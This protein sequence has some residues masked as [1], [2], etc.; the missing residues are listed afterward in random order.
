MPNKFIV[1]TGNTRDQLLDILDKL[2]SGDMVIF[3]KGVHNIPD[4][5]EL[6][7]SVSTVFIGISENPQDTILNAKIT[8]L[9]NDMFIMKNMTLSSPTSDA[10][11]TVKESS[12]AGC[13]NCIFEGRAE[14]EYPNIYIDNSMLTLA[15]CTVRN[16]DTLQGSIFLFNKA[17]VAVERT[18]I[19]M[20]TMSDNSLLN[21]KM[22]MITTSLAVKNSI[23]YGDEP[24]ELLGMNPNMNALTI[25]D[26]SIAN[27][28]KIVSP[29]GKIS[30]KITDSAL[31]IEELEFP[32]T[33]QNNVSIDA[34]SFS[35]ID[36][37]GK[38]STA[39]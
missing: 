6:G 4:D 10:G 24:V 2:K 23:V 33:K 13:N 7:L 8:I 30:A 32:N 36:I 5:L 26:R 35:I 14:N 17:H 15:E 38:D 11:L 21:I 28:H 31:R 37:N 16:N 19:D 1:H 12:K 39:K 18:T 25:E 20:I 22:S 9:N 34:T 3:E 27:F 29:K